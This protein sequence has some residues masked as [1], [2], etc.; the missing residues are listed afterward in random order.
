MTFRTR[1]V[2][3]LGV[4]SFLLACGGGA[5][6]PAGEAN[7]DLVG[8]PSSGANPGFQQPVNSGSP[9][10]GAPGTQRGQPQ[11]NQQGGNQPAAPSVVPQPTDA[12]VV[13]GDPGTTPQQGAF[14]GNGA[15][16]FSDASGGAAQPVMMRELCA[17]AKPTKPRLRLLSPAEI[18][19]TLAELFRV[20]PVDVDVTSLPP[21]TLADHGNFQDAAKAS[22]LQNHVEAY[23]ELAKAVS[24]KAAADNFRY[25]IANCGQFNNEQCRREFIEGLGYQLFRRPLTG[26]ETQ[27]YLSLASDSDLGVN[28]DDDFLTIIAQAMLVSPSFLYRTEVGNGGKLSDYELASELSFHFLGRGPDKRMLDDAGDGKFQDPAFVES[29]AQRLADSDEFKARI[30]DFAERWTGAGS[31]Q[32]LNKNTNAFPQFGAIKEEL[33]KEQKAFFEDVFTDGN[34]TAN[35]LL[36]PG[37]IYADQDLAQFYG[38]QANGGGQAMQKVAV[39]TPDRGGILR[40]G[41]V[42][43][44]HS[45]MDEIHPVRIADF[46]RTAVM[47]QEVPAP[48]EGLMIDPIPFNPALPLRERYSEHSSDP[49]CAGCHQ[50][51]DPLGFT[52]EA[53]NAAGGPAENVNGQAPDTSGM[54]VGIDSISDGRSVELANVNDLVETLLT[55]PSAMTCVARQY[56]RYTFAREE[57]ADENCELEH[58]QARFLQN[59]GN[60]SKLMT[61][62]VATPSFTSRQ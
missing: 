9:A 2:L 29:T 42:I 10:P 39:N 34:A 20:N 13:A 31:V 25:G 59:G 16:V 62:I 41:A 40:M 3:A 24:P 38:V 36:Q 11:T 23:L 47:C 4:S 45:T 46:I 48:P 52:Y 17:V 50:F 5:E 57:T 43:A 14:A 27:N 30:L 8:E 32:R 55:S 33:Y 26:E 21:Y 58:F 7:P 53:Y 12:P 54:L 15:P 51:L 6:S 56:W 28:T 35:A 1:S 44:A 19:S 49:T 60:L 18:Q 37:F 61:D 22:V